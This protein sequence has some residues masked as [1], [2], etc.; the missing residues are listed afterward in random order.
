MDHRKNS[1]PLSAR[2][3]EI[4]NIVWDRGQASVAEVWEIMAARRKVARN[5]IQTIMTR[6]EDK[7]WLGHVEQG[8]A[9]RY[10][11][12]R[13]REPTLRGLVSHL[14]ETAFA[15][16][17]DSL[18]MTLLEARGVAEDEAKRIVALIEQAEQREA[19]DRTEGTMG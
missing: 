9:F 14:V 1:P 11:A 10:Y 19:R 5:T 15:G 3:M 17:T 18:V 13:R 16:S 8:G 12:R 4:M 6:L 2:Q 7:G